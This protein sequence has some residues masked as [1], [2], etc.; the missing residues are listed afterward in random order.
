M[1][2][3]CQQLLWW[4]HLVNADEGKAGVVWFAGK[5][6]WSTPERFECFTVKALY[7]YTSFLFPFVKPNST[8]CILVVLFCRTYRY[9]QHPIVTTLCHWSLPH[10]VNCTRF[11]FCRRRSVF[12][13]CMK[14]LGD[15][16]TNLRTATPSSLAPVKS[17]MVYLSGASLPRLSDAV[18][19]SSSGSSVCMFAFSLLW[20]RYVIGG[21]Y[22]FVL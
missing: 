16:W 10:T 11:C 1:S 21:H 2:A 14:C 5:T 6:V 22:T 13:L 7:K 9:P 15:C 17:R 20:L 19:H 4:W 8:F 18:Q 3:G 12:C